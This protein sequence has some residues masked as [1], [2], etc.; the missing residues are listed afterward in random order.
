MSGS[1]RSTLV[2]DICGDAL[3]WSVPVTKKTARAIGKPKGWRVDKLNR[4][5][6]EKHP[7]LKPRK[8]DKEK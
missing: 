7:T 8:T 5:V 4:D 6:C 2:C 1:G 3:V